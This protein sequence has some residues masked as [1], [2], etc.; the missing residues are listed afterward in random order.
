MVKKILKAVF[1]KIFAFLVIY[2]LISLT[3]AGLLGCKFLFTK[4]IQSTTP[5][6]YGYG[7]FLR[8]VLLLVLSCSS[9]FFLYELIKGIF[10][11]V[12]ICTQV[13]NFAVECGFWC[14]CLITLYGL[15]GAVIMTWLV[16]GKIV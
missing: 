4:A 13:R 16:L 9:L 10:Q 8:A 7:L 5:V 11:G 6:T 3:A 15:V 14:F 2:F 1:K 12:S